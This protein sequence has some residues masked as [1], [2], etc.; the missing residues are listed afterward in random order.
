[1]DKFLKCYKDTT[2]MVNFNINAGKNV[3]TSKKLADIIEDVKTSVAYGEG[4]CCFHSS[5]ILADKLKKEGIKSSLIF[6]NEPYELD[7]KIIEG[8]RVSVLYRSSEDGKYYVANPVEDVEIFTLLG[9]ESSLRYAR[10]NSDGSMRIPKSILG[11][12]VSED[13]SKIPASEFIERYGDGEAS[14]LYDTLADTSKTFT[15][16]TKSISAVT[17]SDFALEKEVVLR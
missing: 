7:G 16:L 11:S 10:Y 12:V 13:A 8:T 3:D 17:T 2:S 9:I 14:V 4:G 5:L 15:E 1:M 6:T